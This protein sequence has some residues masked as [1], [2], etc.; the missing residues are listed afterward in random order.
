MSDSRWWF[1]ICGVSSA[2]AM[3]VARSTRGI[4]F[5]GANT[6]NEKQA[7]VASHVQ[8]W[9]W[10]SDMHTYTHQGVRTRMKDA[11]V[12]GLVVMQRL[13]RD[14]TSDYP[15]VLLCVVAN[16]ITALLAFLVASAYWGTPAGVLVWG[17]LVACI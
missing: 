16:T 11:A 6:D 9:R 7:M 1:L 4:T 13:L 10:P 2:L 17:L 15:Q 12:L 5:Y 3:L 14:R 8:E